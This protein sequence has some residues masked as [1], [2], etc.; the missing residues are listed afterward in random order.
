[1]PLSDEIRDLSDADLRARVAALEEERFRLR[2]RS[3]TEPLDDPLRLRSIRKDIA[4]L[5]TILRQRELEGAS[6]G[7]AS[8]RAR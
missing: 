6:S 1:M 3:A 5:K 4:R 7:A 8:A 2:F